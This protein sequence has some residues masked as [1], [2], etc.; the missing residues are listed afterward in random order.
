MKNKA[1]GIILAAT[2]VVGNVGGHAADNSARPNIVFIISDDQAW[3]DYGFM[4]HPQIATPNLDK[5]AAQSLTLQRGYTPV[6]LCRPSL[7]SIVTGLYPHQHG[8]T[9]N[10][11]ALPD[12]GVNAQT[13][14]GNPK[15]DHYYQ[16]IVNHFAQR[17]NLVRDLTARGYVS[18]QTG[19]WWEGDPVKTAGFSHAMTL[20]TGKGDRHGGKGLEIGR[21]G[22]EPVKN[23]IEEAGNKP[24]LVWYAP[25][26]P[27]DP[28]NPPPDL[29]KK[30]SQL[31]TNAPV[32][33][34][35]GNVEW[36]D[37]TCGEL[38]DYLGQKGLRE[39]T[40]VIYTSDNGW[41]Q[42]PN[43]ANK[44]TPRSKN[45]PYEGGVRTPIMISW[46]AKLKPRMDTTHLASTLDLWPTLAALLQNDA[47]KRL[48]GVN[49][50]NESAVAKRSQIFGET[51]SHDIADVE[52]P[53]RSLES[54]W[55][56]NGWWKLIVP[57]PRNRP[58]TK[59]EL[60]DLKN[61][62][63]EKMDLSDA[64]PE[65]VKSLSR[66]LKKWWTPDTN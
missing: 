31:T 65:R 54:R 11:P 4:G 39:N 64:Q 13:A 22:L 43:Q 37:R 60:Y 9:G 5:L 45:S 63:W 3:G 40:I 24:F 38:L 17:P 41:I 10:D 42:N 36:F 14:R 25:M 21:Q 52:H 1:L 50:A 18:F 7:S 2:L 32:A 66:Q 23:F 6:P 16:T 28:H 59:P 12:K 56:I 53:T 8:V 26:L 62:P 33:A 34:Y 58:N 19:K 35:W 44:F 27:H 47:P 30:Y 61:D 57:D 55:M 48:P 46:P 29:L 15:Y 51:Y 20:G 49:L